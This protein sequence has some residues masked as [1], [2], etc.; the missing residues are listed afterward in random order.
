[1]SLSKGW[2]MR[3]FIPFKTIDFHQALSVQTY[4][5]PYRGLFS[6]FTKR[7]VNNNRARNPTAFIQLHSTMKQ[8]A[9]NFSSKFKQYLHRV[10]FADMNADKPAFMW[11]SEPD[12]FFNEKTKID[13]S[14]MDKTGSLKT[15]ESFTIFTKFLVDELYQGKPAEIFGHSDESCWGL[16]ATETGLAF[17]KKEEL[18]DLGYSVEAKTEM[19][20]AI[21]YDATQKILMFYPNDDRKEPHEWKDVSFNFV[22]NGDIH[23]GSGGGRDF[24]IGKIRYIEVYLYAFSA[25][26]VWKRF[27]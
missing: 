12:L 8:H 3:S 27:T 17:G 11:A 16:K 4:E 21:T 15:L 19:H 1:M 10:S 25:D 5:P 6:P 7:P 2:S 23:I 13:V 26:Q 24:L 14:E 20:V 18:Q 22:C 9:P